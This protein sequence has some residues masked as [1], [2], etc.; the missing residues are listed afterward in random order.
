M[1]QEQETRS[2]NI[3]DQQQRTNEVS[4]HIRQL[5]S[6]DPRIDFKK[7]S[8]MSN[9]MKPIPVIDQNLDDLKNNQTLSALRKNTVQSIVSHNQTSDGNEFFEEN[10]LHSQMSAENEIQNHSLEPD[11]HRVG[12]RTVSIQEEAGQTLEPRINQNAPQVI[13]TVSMD[14][15]LSASQ[16]TSEGR[17]ELN[18]PNR[19]EALPAQ[20]VQIQQ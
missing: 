3:Y 20:T 15:Q 6:T 14:R 19:T 12:A 10:D 8:N 4:N 9:K 16:N 5:Q 1:P 2:L 18:E 7:Y 17:V 11:H 13:H